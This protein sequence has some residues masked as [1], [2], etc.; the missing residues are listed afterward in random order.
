MGKPPLKNKEC[1][2]PFKRLHWVNDK[3]YCNKCKTTLVKNT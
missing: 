3:V 1:V 2:H